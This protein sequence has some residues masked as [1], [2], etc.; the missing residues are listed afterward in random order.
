MNVVITTTSGGLRIGLHFF[1]RR[2]P[3]YLHHPVPRSV[4]EFSFS[5]PHFFVAFE[6]GKITHSAPVTI[7]LTNGSLSGWRKKTG[8]H[9]SESRRSPGL[10]RRTTAT[11]SLSTKF[12]F[13]LISYSPPAAQGSPQ[14]PP[15]PPAQRLRASTS[16]CATAALMSPGFPIGPRIPT[17]FLLP[18]FTLLLQ[19]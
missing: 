6:A 12:A 15:T 3:S 7:H 9:A 2:E 17:L 14:S 19:N 4:V 10:R 13:S 1:R 11:E 16:V 8:I 5:G 18:M